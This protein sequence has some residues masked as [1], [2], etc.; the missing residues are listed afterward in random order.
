[1]SLLYRENGLLEATASINELSFLRMAV[2]DAGMERELDRAGPF[3]LFAPTDAAFEA[4][5]HDRL[6]E[7]YRDRPRLASLIRYHLVGARIAYGDV[8]NR[9][10]VRTLHGEPL[11]LDV[12]NGFRV[13]GARVIEEGIEVRNG[14]IHVIDAVLL[15][16]EERS[17]PDIAPSRHRYYR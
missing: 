9:R 12:E 5:P 10:E 11:D 14:V 17:R 15:P 3:T 13:N 6:N 8:L 16:P 2:K 7:I 4:L 1:M